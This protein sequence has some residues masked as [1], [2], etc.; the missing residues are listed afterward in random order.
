MRLPWFPF[1]LLALALPLTG[2]GCQTYNDR[3]AGTVQAFE[4][5]DFD[6][7]EAGF[8]D[9]DNTGSTFLS[10]AEAGM[11]AFAAGR[12][13]EA[14]DHFERAL[15]ASKDIRERAAV[16]ATNL[17]QSL[18][19]MAINESQADYAGEGYERVMLHVMLA[20]TYLAEI[21]PQDVLVEARL[22]DQL[23]TGE[24]ELYETS[25]GAGGI[26]HL[27]SAVAYELTGKPGEAYI[28]YKRMY[29][30]GVGGTLVESALLRLAERLGRSN[31]LS[32]WRSEFGSSSV[33][34]PPGWPSIVLIGGV[35][36]GPA[37]REFKLDIPVKGGVFSMAVPKF[38]EGQPGGGGPL[39]LVF[40]ASGTVVRSSVVEDVAAVAAE[41]L[42]DRIAWIT[43]R[44]AGR[45]LLKRQLA[46]QMR[47]NKRGAFLGLAADV[48]TVVTERADLRAWRTLPRRW[49]AARAYLPPNEF[50]EIQLREGRGGAV[51]LGSFRMS[52]GETMFVLARS[53][54]SGLV[55]HVI[56]GQSAADVDPPSQPLNP[57]P[58]SGPSTP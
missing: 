35:G 58:M 51:T 34:P 14:R 49:V 11:A 53:L 45:G 30:K 36:M 4:A 44:S 32:V 39:E 10:G 33:D 21:K 41:N 20:L 46:D 1:P 6:R 13:A 37:K 47:D 18:L 43:A 23:V 15:A 17:T 57:S 16:G 48:F 42:D 19:S 27:L 2:V 9:P 50:V 12:F 25:Y 38:D 55:A 5:G 24:E 3:V 8:S 26:G 52:E 56:G 29:E 22:V 40:P 54:Q 28:D 31:E 7:A